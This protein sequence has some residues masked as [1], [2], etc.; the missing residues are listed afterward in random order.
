MA[1]NDDSLGGTFEKAGES[2][3]QKGA[4]VLNEKLSPF[5]DAVRDKGHE[6][7]GG[8]ESLIYAKM[9]D[10]T[11]KRLDLGPERY[12]IATEYAVKSN[13]AA[14]HTNIDRGKELARI[15]LSDEGIKAGKQSLEDLKNSNWLG[16]IKNA[17]KAI[18]GR[19]TV[20][21]GISKVGGG[22]SDF[23]K[24][25]VVSV[26]EKIKPEKSDFPH[27]PAP[28]D[29]N[30]IGPVN[31]IGPFKPDGHQKTGTKIARQVRGGETVEG[32]PPVQ[33]TPSSHKKR[34]EQKA[35]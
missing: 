22:I 25:V 6:I 13:I 3:A 21:N 26:Y 2:L 16:A 35:H 4:K 10:H 31:L 32:Q 28:G 12:V 34:G 1:Q 18:S 24:D 9:S 11:F 33:N 23:G 19:Y 14:A 20:V 29:P 15:A 30:F 7:I 17:F 27:T 5:Y 8:Q